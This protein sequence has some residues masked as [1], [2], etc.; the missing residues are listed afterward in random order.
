MT[1][2]KTPAPTLVYV[3]SYLSSQECAT[4]QPSSNRVVA[5][6]GGGHYGD[7]NLTLNKNHL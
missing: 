5:L 7:N 1:H 4:I 2:I 6:M 3:S